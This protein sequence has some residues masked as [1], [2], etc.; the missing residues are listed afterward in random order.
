MSAPRTRPSLGTGLAAAF[1]LSA[2]GAALLA[3]LS[4]WLGGATALRAVIA[5]LGLA[6]TLYVIGRSGERV[7][8]ITTVACWIVIASGAW[9]F[10][11]PLV[12]YVLLHVGLV[13]L[14]RA[15]S[16][17]GLAA[18]ASR[19][20]C[21]RARRGV[22]RLGRAALGQRLARSLVFFPRASVPRVHSRDADTTRPCGARRGR[23]R[24]RA[25]PSRRGSGRAAF[26]LDSLIRNLQLDNGART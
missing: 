21:E 18:G 23:R 12:G 5:L 16:L 2:C 22:R 9:L 4:P 10:G 20:G 8:R 25:R 1:V 24:L 26:V 13:W 6:Y 15:L 19:L 3:A 7:G 14:V 11:L 17:L